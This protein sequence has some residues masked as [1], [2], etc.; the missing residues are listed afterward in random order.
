MSRRSCQLTHAAPARQTDDFHRLA[1]HHAEHVLHAVGDRV[2]VAGEA[3]HEVASRVLAERGEVEPQ[4]AAIKLLPEIEGNQGA[5]PAGV[6]RRRDAEGA[7]QQRA[8]EQAD[9]DPHQGFEGRRGQP[10]VGD[11]IPAIV[12]SEFLAFAAQFLF[13]RTE[14]AL[15]VAALACGQG[16]ELL[17]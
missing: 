7:F 5:N 16:G 1:D 6:I 15:L 8:G 4:R 12:A 10:A 2:H 14:L 9:A 11:R 17:R 3:I 13:K